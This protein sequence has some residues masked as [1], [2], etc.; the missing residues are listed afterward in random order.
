[1]QYSQDPKWGSRPIAKDARLDAVVVQFDG[2][3]STQTTP[4]GALSGIQAINDRLSQCII[5]ELR[6]GPRGNQDNRNR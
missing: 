3:S 2:T 6:G 4:I 1:M 5:A